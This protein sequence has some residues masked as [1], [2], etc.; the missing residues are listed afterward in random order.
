MRLHPNLPQLATQ[1]LLALD[2]LLVNVTATTSLLD[3]RAPSLAGSRLSTSYFYKLLSFRGV[4]WAPV[5]WVWDPI[6]PLKHRVFL[7]LVF[8][9]RLNTKDNMAR[10]GWSVADSN[11]RCDLCPAL[12]SV[13]HLLLRCRPVNALWHRLLLGPLAL[14]SPDIQSFVCQAVDQLA[15]KHKW[16]VTF[17]ACVV[18]VWQARNDRLSTTSAGRSLTLGSMQLI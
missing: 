10:K 8:W 5:P 15:F 4:R 7:W 9:G 11:A 14:H 3:T 17:A 12:E 6:I 13:D 2:Q 18:T 16:N 1:E